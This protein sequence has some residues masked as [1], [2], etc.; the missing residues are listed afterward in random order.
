MLC[1]D[2]ASNA[3]RTPIGY[4]TAPG[5]QL[6]WI[7][8]VAQ[9]DLSN[10]PTNKVHEGEGKWKELQRLKRELREALT[11]ARK[12]QQGAVKNLFEPYW[13]GGSARTR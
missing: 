8:V 6:H 7:N 12:I 1:N 10:L 4:G 2:L 13:G 3:F 9:Q 5:C 11:L